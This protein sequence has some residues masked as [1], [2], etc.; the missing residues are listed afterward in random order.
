MTIESR[1]LI[2]VPGPLLWFS[3]PASSG[4]R[5]D[6]EPASANAVAPAANPRLK[7]LVVDDET[8]I[9]DSVAEI[10]NRNGYDASALYSGTEAIRRVEEEC[11]D[12]VIADVIMPDLDGVQLAIAVRACCPKTRIVLFSGNAATSGLLDRATTDGFFFELLTKPV[13]PTQLLKVL[14]T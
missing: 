8:L 5:S 10:L 7:V 4:T 11:P 6:G 13:H 9:A 3:S 14:K 1:T 2:A 12:I